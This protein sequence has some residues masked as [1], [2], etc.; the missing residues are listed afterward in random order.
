MMCSSEFALGFQTKELG[1][2]SLTLVG[3]WLRVMMGGAGKIC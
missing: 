2:H 1:L 3:Q